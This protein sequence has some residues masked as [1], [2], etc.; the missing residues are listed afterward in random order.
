[1][2]AVV[3]A[4][5]LSVRSSASSSLTPSPL[6]PVAALSFHVATSPVKVRRVRVKT[7]CSI[8]ST[9][10][11]VALQPSP[12]WAHHSS[13]WL[14]TSPRLGGRDARTKGLAQR[15]SLD[16]QVG[17]LACIGTLTVCQRIT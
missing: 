3:A 12:P 8:G 10:F 13:N 2:A 4:V 16:L 14:Y 7:G 6:S 5:S 15:G 17:S 1:M 11:A 9:G